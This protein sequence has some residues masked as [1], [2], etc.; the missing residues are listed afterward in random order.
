MPRVVRTDRADAQDVARFDRAP[1]T[2]ATRTDEGFLVAPAQITR[3]GVLEYLNPD[4][5]TRREL[6]LDA[7]VFAPVS[8]ATY[9]GRP[10]TR[11]HPAEL[12]SSKTAKGLVVGALSDVRRA[13]D[14]Q[15]VAATVTIYDADAIAAVDAGER[16]LSVG[17]KARLEPIPG[18]T[19]KMPD[20]TEVR[21]DFLQRDIRANHTAI[22]RRGRAGESASIRLDSAGHQT[23]G[24]EPEETSTMTPE[25]I[26]AM[27]AENARLKAEAETS[28]KAR[29]DSV[30]ALEAAKAEAAAAKAA[31]EAHQKRLDEYA[32]RDKAAAHKA[33]VAR[34][35]PIV[36]E[37]PETLE[38]LDG[39]EV[40]RKALAKLT[41]TLDLAGK[42]AAF[43]APA[44]ET[45]MSLVRTDSAQAIAGAVLLAVPRNDGD[46]HEQLAKAR[47]EARKAA[48]DAHKTKA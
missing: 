28:T 24:G 7:D 44:F 1:I 43:I 3:T 23:A 47:E 36:G 16:E 39:V 10:I 33:L 18:G 15:H 31:A 11:G 38:R 26:A 2:V 40:Q 8:L 12:L 48:A 37:K 34:V 46:A 21:A 45:A 17:Y 27:Q 32:A 9:Q 5:T 22:V 25:Q 35:A 20:G 42:D 6:R 19:F 14:G 30:T 41:P 29:T 13:D 4:G